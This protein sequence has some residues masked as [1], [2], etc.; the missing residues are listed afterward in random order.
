MICGLPGS[1]KT[2]LARR[3]EAE[4]AAVRFT[5]D[6]WMAALG[7][8]IYDEARD[9]V[10]AVAMGHCTDVAGQGHRRRPGQRILVAEGT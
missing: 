3:V 5:P 10:E 8:H 9:R 1:G 2:T 4:S 7:F 6:E